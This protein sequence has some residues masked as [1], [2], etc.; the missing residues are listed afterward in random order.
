MAASGAAQSLRKMDELGLLQVVLPEVVALKGVVQSTF[1]IYDVYEHTLATVAEAERLAVWPNP[2]LAPEEE[3]FLSPFAADL[4]AHFAPVLCE[5]RTRATLLKFAALC[6]DLGKP[7]T[8]TVEED[9]RIR[10]LGH[11]NVGAEM[12]SELLTRLKFSAKEIRLVSTIVKHHMRPTWLE[13]QPTVTGKA[14]YRFFRDTG[15]AG[16]DVLI[17]VLAD[18]LATRG[19]ALRTTYREHW[20]SYL[21]LVYLLLDHYFH[22]PAQAVAPPTLVTGSD[23]MALLGLPAGP[24]VGQ[25]LEEVREAQAEGQVRT[26]DEAEE[27]LRRRSPRMTNGE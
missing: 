21:R 19:E 22:K 27:M 3:E 15:D 14:I 6:H 10:N 18:Q 5:G 13:K 2:S 7:R 25:L 24:E 20:L 1:H 17:L 9:G 23:V 12:S 16:V 11:E 26:K 8:V 4:A